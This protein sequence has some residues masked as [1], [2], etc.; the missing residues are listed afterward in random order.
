MSH[1]ITLPKI[2]GVASRQA[3]ADLPP[4]S[5]ERELGKEGFYGPSTQMYHRHPPTGWSDVQGPLRPRAFDTTQ[6]EANQ[7]SPWN[8]FRLLSNPHLQFRLW[9][10]DSS[11]DHL[12]RNA[13]GDE[14]LFIHQGS[15]DLYCDY[16]HLAFREGDYILLPRGTLWR[17]E[18]ENPLCMLL[19]EATADSYQ[20]PDK[21]IVGNHAVFDPAVLDTP[22]ID[23][24]FLA[25]QTESEWRVVVKRRGALSTIIYPF[26]P[27]DAV[28]WHGTLLPVRL[29]WRDIRPVM[30]HRYHI[31]P[32]AHTTFAASRFVVCTFCPRPIESDPGALKVP[33]FHNND[34]YDEVIFYHQGE[35]FSRDNI[36]P[37]MM[38]L[39]PSGI[40]HGPHPKAF[41]AGKK[42]LRKETN[43]VAVMVDARDALEVAEFPPGVEWTGYVDS[44]K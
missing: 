44:W 23:E 1:W 27:L 38:T 2:E 24:K 16:G 4:E 32:S 26:N 12:V 10:T 14:L 15:G 21:G 34:D 9:K 41:E 42:A 33:F 40:T 29:N 18:I 39:H 19:L 20:L 37:G 11:M 3:H 25:Q 43:E 35:F 36:H 30:S 22:A 6:L 5:Y 13:D 28:G 31:P 7:T 8:A 17:V